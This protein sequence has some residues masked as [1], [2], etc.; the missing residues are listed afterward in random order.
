MVAINVFAAASEAEA[1]RQFTS[2]QQ[3]F[4][5]LVRGAPG[6]IPL[7]IDDIDAYWTPTERLH[8]ESML[9]C[10]AVGSPD[11]VTAKLQGFIEQTGMDELMVTGLYA[12]PAARLESLALTAQ[13][14]D[15]L[16]P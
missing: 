12:D 7:P 8:A 14:R 10:S 13:I 16:N 1:R 5:N 9:A 4:A 3:A 6:Q 2:H 15:R 11:T